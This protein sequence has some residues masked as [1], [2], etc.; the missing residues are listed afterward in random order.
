MQATTSADRLTVSIR[1]LEVELSVGVRDWERS[2]DKTQLVLIDV[3][4]ERPCP[5]EPPEDIAGTIDYGAI[6]RFV[7][8]DL[9]GRGHTDLLETL[10]YALSSFCL[11]SFPI[12]RCRVRLS[13]PHVY[14]GLATPSVEIVRHRAAE[15]EGGSGR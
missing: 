13:K 12:E 8:E 11:E 6:V 15:E 3:D 14:N 4:L 1:D 9:A 7:R 5:P 10:A 2:P